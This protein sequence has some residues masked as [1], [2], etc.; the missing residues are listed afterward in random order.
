[1][2]PESGSFEWRD[3]DV[4]AL[5]SRS[6][7]KETCCFAMGGSIFRFFLALVA[8]FCS[9]ICILFALEPGVRRVSLWLMDPAGRM[10][11]VG[12]PGCRKS[13]NLVSLC[14]IVG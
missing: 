13:K 12:S 10:C 7:E 9:L 3:E 4:L 2:G 14:C 1:M 6:V 8:K 5:S 11:G